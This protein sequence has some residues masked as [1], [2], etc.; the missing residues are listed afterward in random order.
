MRHRAGYRLAQRQPG[1][2]CAPVMVVDTK[3]EA[4]RM[5]GSSPQSGQHGCEGW[6]ITNQVNSVS[7]ENS[8][9]RAE[10]GSMRMRLKSAISR[11]SCG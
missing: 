2:P 11:Y 10:I 4:S 7:I 3:R 8:T 6:A 5:R 9:A 1:A